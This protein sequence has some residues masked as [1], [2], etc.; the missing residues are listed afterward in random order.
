MADSST[1]ANWP[2]LNIEFTCTLWSVFFLIVLCSCSC[3]MLKDSHTNDLSCAT[4]S[5]L[6]IFVVLKE[7]WKPSIGFTWFHLVSPGFTWFHLFNIVRKSKNVLP[8]ACS[9][10]EEKNEKEGGAKKVSKGLWFSHLC[11]HLNNLAY[12]MYTAGWLFSFMTYLYSL[13]QWEY[14]RPVSTRPLLILFTSFYTT[15]LE[16]KTYSCVQRKWKNGY[17]TCTSSCRPLNFVKIC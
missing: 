8:W 11:I 16:G 12:T 3:N 4:Q 2:C 9:T 6:G 14:M 13:F 7:S 10:R 1:H 15:P 17:R 5:G